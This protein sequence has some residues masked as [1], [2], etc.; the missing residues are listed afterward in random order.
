MPARLQIPPGMVSAACGDFIAR[1]FVVDPSER[2]GIPQMV[3][4]PWFCQGL[5]ALGLTPQGE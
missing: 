5:A 3:L 2:M 1:L 4:H